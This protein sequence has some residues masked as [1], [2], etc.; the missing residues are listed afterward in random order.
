MVAFIG[1]TKG[2]RV[3][4][5][6]IESVSPTDGDFERPLATRICQLIETSDA[7]DGGELAHASA[8]LLIA[9]RLRDEIAGSERIILLSRPTVHSHTV[10]LLGSDVI[11]LS[12]I[13]DVAAIAARALL[14]MVARP[15][16]L[17]V[18]GQGVLFV[19][20]DRHE[21]MVRPLLDGVAPVV[22]NVRSESTTRSAARGVFRALRDAWK[23]SRWLPLSARIRSTRLR[24]EAADLDD[25]L[26]ELKHDGVEE[27]WFADTTGH[28][29]RLLAEAG[30]VMGMQVVVLQHG[31]VVNP[32]RY[33][34]P[35]GVTF[36]ART[37][38]DAHRLQT[39]MADPLSVEWEVGAPPVPRKTRPG[40]GVMICPSKIGSKERFREVGCLVTRMKASRTSVAIRFHPDE[41]MKRLKAWRLGLPL[42]RSDTPLAVIGSEWGKAVVP[43]KSTVSEDLEQA[44]FSLIDG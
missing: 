26:K 7:Y 35:T 43:F 3:G 9:D 40:V 11:P 23:A 15:R 19:T 10:A 31:R 28:R 20:N 34:P 41:P 1:R 36:R 22:M 18:S 29:V 37:A 42:I 8:G 5:A 2:V 24:F 13:A 33:V 25:F 38:D 30:V 14:R 17:D 32:C 21:E 39:V 4:W 16:C 27:L 12:V 44:G 6:Y